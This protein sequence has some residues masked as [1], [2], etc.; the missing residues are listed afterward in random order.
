MTLWLLEQTWVTPKACLMVLGRLARAFEFRRPLFATLNQVWVL[1][2]LRAAAA[3]AGKALVKPFKLPAEA[4]AELLSAVSLLPMAYTDML[5]ALDAVALATD[6][7]EESG[8]LC[9]TTGLT[10]HGA[11]TAAQPVG[12]EGLAFTPR[13]AMSS[14]MPQALLQDGAAL[15]TVVLFDLFG[16]VGASMVALSRCPCRVVMYVSSEIDKAAK[17]CARQRW[18]GVIELGDVTKVTSEAWAQLGRVASEVASLAVIAAGPPC[19]DLSGLN[20]AGQGLPGSKSGLFFELPRAFKAIEQAFGIKRTHWLVENVAGMRSEDLAVFSQQLGVKPYRV[21]AMGVGLARR[22]RLYWL[23][24]A[25]QAR[26]GVIDITDEE[27]YFK[28]KL[29]ASPSDFPAW[30]EDGWSLLEPKHALPTSAKLQKGSHLQCTETSY[31]SQVYNFEDEN[32][33]WNTGRTA[34]RIPAADERETLMGFDRGCTRAAVKESVPSLETEIIRSSLIGNSFSV[35]VVPY[36]LAQLLARKAKRGAPPI[37]PFLQ[38]GIAP[39]ARGRAPDF[40]ATEIQDHDLEQQR[41]FKYLR[42]ASRGGTDVRLD[43]QVG[44]AVNVVKWRSRTAARFSSRYLH[45]LDSQVAASVLA[46]VR[47]S[48][49][50][51][52]GWMRGRATYLLAT[53]CY[54]MRA[55]IDTDD[56]PG[57]VPSRWFDGCRRLLAFWAATGKRPRLVQEID[58]GVAASIEHAWHTNGSLL[59]VNNTLAAAPF[60]TP[61]MSGKLKLS[62]KLQNAR[63]RLEPNVRALPLSPLCAAAIAGAFCWSGE[64]LHL[65]RRDVQ[66]FRERGVAILALRMTKTSRRGGHSELA[67]V[68]SQ[69]AARLPVKYV[70]PLAPDE[71]LLGSPRS[72]FRRLFRQ[73]LNT[74]FTSALLRLSA[75]APAAQPS[76]AVALL[77][78]ILGMLGAACLSAPVNQLYNFAVTSRAYR[79]ASGPAGWLALSLGFLDST[80]VLRDEAGKAYGLTPT[81]ARDLFLRCMYVANDLYVCFAMIERLFVAAGRRWRAGKGKLA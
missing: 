8:G 3:S 10:Q 13:G 34:W 36:I 79:E 61:R 54:P 77:A 48:A 71:L 56:N 81:L 33:L 15:P 23:S 59:Q 14:R 20:A 28:V 7:S 63:L 72:E 29:H 65:R 55:Y 39:E 43:L 52:W 18:P 67:V 58:E 53:G 75:A 32:L 12:E 2:E 27:K 76:A 22:P 11:Q 70:A 4:R 69:A 78:D 66:V 49:R 60:F 24:W 17:R 40:K 1:P 16:G 37:V 57:D 50:R 68:R 44:A 46:R 6:A 45:L 64:M 25:L 47:S 74:M 19:T 38:M 73:V 26:A 9:Y 21:E 30:A 42:I 51:L 35:Q 41:V 31:V 80:Y 5:A 62:W